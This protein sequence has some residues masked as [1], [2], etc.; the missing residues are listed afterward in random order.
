M[1]IDG[2]P[3]ALAAS[4]ATHHSS[5]VSGSAREGERGHG[6]EGERR[7]EAGE[8]SNRE[9]IFL[10]TRE[11]D[12]ERTRELYTSLVKSA[13][14]DELQQLQEHPT[15]SGER[16]AD[17]MAQLLADAVTGGASHFTRQEMEAL[18]GSSS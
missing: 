16:G 12:L 5:S 6:R 11:T 13:F 2:A 4:L 7:E 1:D 15:L 17:G 9:D 3:P 10:H 18:A 8:G 14:S